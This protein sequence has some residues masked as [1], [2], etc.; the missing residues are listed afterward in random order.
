MFSIII[1]T[2]NRPQELKIC[3]KSLNK[4]YTTHIEF[5]V[6]V[7]DDCSTIHYEPDFSECEFNYQYIKLPVNQ[8]PSGARNNGV[9]KAKHEWLM[10]LDDDDRFESNKLSI[11][12]E[13]I[14]Q[15]QDCEFFY[16]PAFI[17]MINENFT[18]QTRPK[19]YR[20][21]GDMR[22]VVY[23]ENPV[24]GAPNIII[25]KSLFL[26][27]GMFDND[28]KA[29]EDYELIIR[30]V[31]NF[32]EQLSKYID[33]PLTQCSY[34]T[35]KSSVSKSYINTKNACN[36]IREKYCLSESDER[37]FIRN[38]NLMCAYSLIMN[39]DR[40]AAWFYLRAFMYSKE[41]GHLAAAIMSALY[42]ESIF[43]FKK[44]LSGL[45]RRIGDS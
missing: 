38:E 45:T 3:L 28:M 22:H 33:I 7:I 9:L 36:Y 40:R 25:S 13:I 18:Y 43:I 20:S 17:H 5:E 37:L 2:Y 35:K 39:K 6:I 10:F 4:L 11:A 8:G 31:S 15:N 14:E 44:I 42:P 19:N 34:V 12:A 30:L 21:F 1:P 41:A 26:R 24:G 16:H 32:S 27:A 23:R 29:I